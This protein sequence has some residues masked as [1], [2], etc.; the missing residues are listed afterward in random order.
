MRAAVILCALVV[1]GCGAGA[2]SSSALAPTTPSASKD[3]NSPYALSLDDY[4]LRMKMCM[5]ERG[6][7][8]TIEDDG[9]LSGNGDP[10]DVREAIDAC[11]VAVDPLR[12]EGFK[13]TPEQLRALYRY[14]V[15][16]AGCLQSAGYAAVSAPPEQVFVDS[17][18]A[19]DPVGDI[20]ATG[21]PATPS[22]LKRCEQ[23]PDRPA[24][25]GW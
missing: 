3:P 17:E 10:N 1:W 7:D 22:D 13:A 24:W 12:A 2:S 25:I 14:R 11:Q 4:L 20:A 6:F 23:T 19:W 9:S 18:G 16:L 21:R 8:V 5:A 15:S